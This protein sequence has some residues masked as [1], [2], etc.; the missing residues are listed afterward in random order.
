MLYTRPELQ[1]DSRR[2]AV[3]RGKLF[4]RGTLW[5]GCVYFIAIATLVAF[6]N[7]PFADEGTFGGSALN[8][9][10]TGFSGNPSTPPYGLGIPLIESTR[11]NFWVMPGYLYA[12]AAWYRIAPQTIISGRILSV[13]F[14]VAALVLFYLMLRKL[15]ASRLVSA[16]A[17]V[18]LAADYNMILDSSMVRMDSLSLGLNFAAWL[19]YLTLRRKSIAGALFLAGAV[20]SLSFV[21]HPN[22]IIAFAG[23]ILLAWLFD[24]PRL[25]LRAALAFIAGAAIPALAAASLI[26][27][28]PPVFFQQMRAHSQHRFEG[29]LNPIQ[30]VWD[31]FLARYF[32]PFGGHR[33]Y[34]SKF[35]FAHWALLLVLLLYLASSAWVLAR[36]RR[37]RLLLATGGIF[38]I[39]VV[40]F[41]FFE[42]GKLGYYNIHLIPWFCLFTAMAAL[43][44]MRR[45]AL[46]AVAVAGVGFIVLVNFIWNAYL[47]RSNQ[48]WT[49]YE[50]AVSFLR[51]NM[52]PR[53]VALTHAYFG[54]DLGFDRIDEDYT[55]VDIVRRAPR[56]VLVDRWITVPAT[57][58]AYKYGPDPEKTGMISEQEKIDGA[59]L[60]LTRYRPVL[61][62]PDYIVYERAFD[63]L[64]RGG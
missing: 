54:Y 3:A 17:V 34:G 61:Q 16:L 57:T 20:A 62:T 46:R 59:V 58:K 18:L 24:R 2:K 23:V 11:Y 51:S 6:T 39:T 36:F 38:L 9:I 53:D 37:S 43:E 55:L 52:R 22:G 50:R 33:L 44:M 29:F 19:S 45:K 60:L 4:L 32:Y 47:I 49:S 64:K 63:P 28:N 14:G 21:T 48:Y 13:A 26:I 35:A 12:L 56:F 25:T 42:T 5:A 30:S 10:R 40:Y 8:I 7:L 1:S 31:E 41:T 15:A 27:Q